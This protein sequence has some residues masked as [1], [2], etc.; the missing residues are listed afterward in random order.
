MDQAVK[1]QMLER[2]RDSVDEQRMVLAR[3]IEG[4]FR[5]VSNG[6]DE[7]DNTLADMQASIEKMDELIARI[8]ASDA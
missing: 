5:F 2:W 8:E 3:W 1:A 6:V 7:T 4:Q